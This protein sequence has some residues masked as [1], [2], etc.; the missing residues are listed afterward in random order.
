MRGITRSQ[1]LAGLRLAAL[2]GA[3]LLAGTSPAVATLLRVDALAQAFDAC[4]GDFSEQ[5][6]FSE[7][8][9][10]FVGT[11][12]SAGIGG[13]CAG[14]TAVTDGVVGP[15]YFR[16]GAEILGGVATGSLV[17][18]TAIEMRDDVVIDAPGLT[19]TP[20]A[21]TAQMEIVVNG[22]F[23]GQI[24][25]GGFDLEIRLAGAG[26]S[27][28]G[29]YDPPFPWDP[30]IFVGAGLP[31]GSHDSSGQVSFVLELPFDFVFGT[32]F[33]IHV[34]GQVAA[35]AS[36]DSPTFAAAG[37]F[38]EFPGS[39][40]WLGIDGLPVGA[41]TTLGAIDWIQAAPAPAA[42]EPPLGLLAL[43]GAGLALA[44]RRRQ[45]LA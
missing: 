29:D 33:E 15:G 12:A 40:H 39:F 13:P 34:M 1:W 36:Y 3:S 21:A 45:R 41:Q 32:P 30:V 27:Y 11:G 37:G 38:V 5:D 24:G 19:G 2:A 26:P 35:A 31:P 17:A 6:F 28:A 10:G 22:A 20:G 9:Q 18:Q 25:G 42:G 7:G 16:A 44:R 8:Q 43:L 4:T 14:G 23:G